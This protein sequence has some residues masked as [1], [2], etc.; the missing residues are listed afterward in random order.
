MQVSRWFLA[1]Y[2]YPDIC[3]TLWNYGSSFIRGL[4]IQHY[5]S[6][7]VLLYRTLNGFLLTEVNQSG[8]AEPKSSDDDS[9][10]SFCEMSIP[11]P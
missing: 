9:V 4:K 3:P 7:S 5:F 10:I 1:F 6:Q 8:G 2:F 11:I